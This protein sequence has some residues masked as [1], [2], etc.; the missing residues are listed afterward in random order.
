MQNKAHSVPGLTG[1]VVCA[2]MQQDNVSRAGLADV[3]HHAL[4]VQA[5]R[6]CTIV[7]VVVSPDTG[8][9]ENAQVVGPRWPWQPH[10]IAPEIAV[11]KFCHETACACM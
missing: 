9:S 10:C 2:R 7:S 11:L 5:P 6:L 4:E 1:W 3:I 8:I